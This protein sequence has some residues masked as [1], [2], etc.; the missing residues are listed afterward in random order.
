MGQPVQQD[1][2]GDWN[3]GD[4]G[5]RGDRGQ[6]NR[7]DRG[8]RGQWN[9]ND[10]RGDRGQ[11]NGGNNYRGDRDRWNNNNRSRWSNNWRRDSRYDWRNYRNRNRNA[12]RLPRYYAPRGYGYGYN[13]YGIGAILGSLFFSQNYWIND[14]FYYRLPPAYGP[15]RWVRYY[16]DALLVDIY[17]GQ[18]VDVEYDIFW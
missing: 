1:R 14:P 12:Y 15:Y 9:G 8:D 18:V 11:W 5:D 2:R 16:N 3:R 7:G 6:W 4:R 17:T 10:N 13:R